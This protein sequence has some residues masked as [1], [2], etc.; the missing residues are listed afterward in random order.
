M[1]IIGTVTGYLGGNGELKHLQSGTQVLE[2]SIASKGRKD[3]NGQP[4]TEW[5]RVKVWGKRAEALAPLAQ[6]G[7][8]V[9]AT[10][11]LEI[12]RFNGQNGPQ[13][14]V[15]ISASEIDFGPQVEGERQQQQAPQQQQQQQQHAGPQGWGA[16]PQGFV[17]PPNAPPYYP[18]Q[19]QQT[20]QHAGP[21]NGYAP[22]QGAPQQGRRLPF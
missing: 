7:R 20:P 17:P 11:S 22:P 9:S 15:E 12:S 19:Q 8:F 4:E 18:P 6:K 13:S 2:M 3:P 10:G 21:P 14:K 5:V 16:P 1:T